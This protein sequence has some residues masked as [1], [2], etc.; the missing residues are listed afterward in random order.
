MIGQLLA[1]NVKLGM[2]A[3]MTL[4]D[5]TDCD[6]RACLNTL[7]FL[8]KKHTRIRVADVARLSIGQKDMT[9][10]VFSIWNEL[11]CG[12]VPATPYSRP[13]IAKQA[14]HQARFSILLCLWSHNQL[15]DTHYF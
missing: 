2:Q 4:A 5:K 6:V 15:W 11:L 7:Q 13:S 10:D 12:K 9:K 1:S 14:P 8:S 3:L